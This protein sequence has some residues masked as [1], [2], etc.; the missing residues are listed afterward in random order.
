LTDYTLK[1]P[2]VPQIEKG[3]YVAYVGKGNNSKLIKGILRKRYWW[4]FEDN[5]KSPNINFIW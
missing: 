5:I 3:K 2:Y 4:T 1:L